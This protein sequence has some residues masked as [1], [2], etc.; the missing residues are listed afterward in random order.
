MEKN[1]Q[2][3]VIG[4]HLQTLSTAL[5]HDFHSNQTFLLPEFILTPLLE[6]RT[7]ASAVSVHNTTLT[8]CLSKH[9]HW[10]CY[11]TNDE[12]FSGAKRRTSSY[13]FV[14][15]FCNLTLLFFQFK[16]SSKQFKY[17]HSL[18]IQFNVINV[19]WRGTDREWGATVLGRRTLGS[20]TYSQT[21]MCTRMHTYKH[22]HLPHSVRQNVGCHHRVE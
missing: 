11:F 9:K 19:C 13:L 20:T 2:W 8:N 21:S 18:Y 15:F 3:S 22:A 6:G 5:S 16:I 7:Q 14:I 12:F 17:T 4:V 1:A 10:Q